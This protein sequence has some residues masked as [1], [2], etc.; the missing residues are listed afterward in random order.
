MHWY[1]AINID[2]L[3][4]GIQP[5][6]STKIDLYYMGIAILQM[7]L[8]Q[9]HVTSPTMQADLVVFLSWDAHVSRKI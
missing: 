9:N 2:L 1:E 3:T 4:V 6:C 8:F 5:W 7:K